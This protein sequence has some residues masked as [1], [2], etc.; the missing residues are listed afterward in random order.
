MNSQMTLKLPVVATSYF[1]QWTRVFLLS[2]FAAQSWDATNVRFFGRFLEKLQNRCR[3]HTF[4][5]LAKILRYNANRWNDRFG[6]T[7]ETHRR[8]L[9]IYRGW[10]RCS[11][12]SRKT[13]W[14]D[15]VL[16]QRWWTSRQFGRAED[17]LKRRQRWCVKQNGW[18]EYAEQSEIIL[19]PLHGLNC[20]LQHKTWNVP[21]MTRWDWH[22]VRWGDERPITKLVVEQIVNGD[23]ELGLWWQG[24][25]GGMRQIQRPPHRIFLKTVMYRDKEIW[26]F[27]FPET[28][29]PD[30]LHGLV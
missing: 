4:T 20:V 12:S 3:F 16:P 1:T 10:R 19:S 22:G 6:F 28:R 23:D 8:N 21:R 30:G 2:C 5:W 13:N 7:A 14:S 11:E 26:V 9:H 25:I 29:L 27:S 18:L 17:L 15:R 24:V